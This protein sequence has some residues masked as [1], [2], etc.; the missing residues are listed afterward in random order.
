MEFKDY[1]QI[2]GVPRSAGDEDIKKAFRKLARQYHPDVAKNKKEAEEKFKEINEANE[3]LSDPA[4]RKRYDELGANWKQQGAGFQPP[5]GGHRQSRQRRGG[6]PNEYQFNGTGFSDFFEQ[7][8][9]GSRGAGTGGFE[10]F[11]TE[12]EV[13]AARGRD[14]EA[15]IMVT[16]EEVA[17]GSVRSIS[18]KRAVLCQACDGTGLSG[19]RPCP[20]CGGSGQ[21]ERIDQYQVKIPAGIHAGSKLRLSGRG[22]K[23]HGSGSA[24]DLYLRVNV[25]RHP[26]FH[27]EDD[28]LHHELELAPWE[29]ALGATVSVPTLSG[30][31]QIK[32][33]P[34]TQ[35]GH[36]LRVRG[37]GLPVHKSS[38]GDLHVVTKIVVP[39]KTT[40]EE[41]GLW[42]QL[43]SKSGFKP[44][45]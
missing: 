5:P 3:V 32:I 19:Q 23:G 43:A 22:E 31:V 15:D 35:S 4:K 6:D 12:E 40:D 21:T 20:I 44:R 18:L 41:R 17:N 14:V 37:R 25:A 29:A 11:G 36:T 28:I 9:S 16:L 42:E 7:F 1:Y 24:G 30:K 13:F 2:L 38:P 33:P 34:G 45:E 8:F 27:I 10:S 26:E 39:E